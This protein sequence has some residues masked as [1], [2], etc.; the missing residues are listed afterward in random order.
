MA[1]RTRF[2]H[3][4]LLVLA[5]LLPLLMPV[6]AGTGREQD[7]DPNVLSYGIYWFGLNNARQKFVPG[8]ANPYFDP[9][10]PTIIFV[11]GWQ[12]GISATHPPDFEYTYFDG[13][14]SR[15][16]NTANAWI[17]AGWNIGIFYWNQ[18]SDEAQVVDAEAKIWTTEG[19]KGMRWRKGDGSYEDAPPGT[20]SAGELFYQTYVAAMT[21]YEY[22][23]G[24]IRIA[25]HSLGSQMAVRLT[26]LVADGIAAGEVPAHL[27]PDRVALLD[28]YW[29]LGAKPYLDGKETAELV[30]ERVAELLP[31]GVLFEWYRS[32][33]L[34]VP[35]NGDA[36]DD[37]QPMMLYVE[38]TPSF[39]VDNMSKHC[40][41]RHLYFWSYAFSGPPEC[42][43]DGCLVG[44]AKMLSKMSDQRLA[45]LMRS[46][47]T[48]AQNA[49][50]LTAS[51]DDDTY[52]S[53]VRSDAPY[54]IAQLVASPAAPAVGQVVTVT[55][56]VRDKSGAPVRDGV[57][58]AFDTDVGTISARSATSGGLAIAHLTSSVP[59]VAHVTATTRGT[60]GTVQNTVTVT[61]SAAHTP[62]P[63]PTATSTS[64]PTSTP[65][66]TATSTPTWT[67]TPTPTPMPT[68]TPTST[69]TPTPTSTP[70]PTWTATPTSIVMRVY[71]PLSLRTQR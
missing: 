62:T 64:T 13:I 10:K 52:L 55:A 20:P 11:H 23:G 57:L 44:P 68:A 31:Q 4:A 6:P 47:Y 61:F 40:A 3:S 65:T 43:G 39:A 32:S 30:R 16:V 58:V 12:P 28:P 1:Y 8:E 17:Q 29:S 25:G 50:A 37:L 5:L 15:T 18:F 51:P 69:P 60:G 42:T 22:T 2:P 70:M 9:S 46:D 71:L 41:A 19:P 36:N 49:G 24:Y 66:P 54:T 14:F 21:E 63:T 38:M 7:Y 33:V 67:S 45:A 27:L 59:G 26:K 56:T 34:T 35:P 53:S 48:W